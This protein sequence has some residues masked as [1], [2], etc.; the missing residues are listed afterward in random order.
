MIGWI[1]NIADHAARVAERWA[2]GAEVGFPVISM[3]AFS[4]V[5]FTGC[6]IFAAAL[7]PHDTV[8]SVEPPALADPVP[9][10]IPSG[11]RSTASP[12]ILTVALLQQDRSGAAGGSVPPAP[13]TRS[14]DDLTITELVERVRELE[15]ENARLRMTNAELELRLAESQEQYEN[16]ESFITDHDTY[17]T[18]FEEYTL[19]RELREREMRARAAADAKARR[20]A[21]RE[22]RRQ[23][24]LEARERHRREQ[25]ARRGGPTDVAG[26]PEAEA[27]R[28]EEVLRRAGYT[29]VGEA[30]YV[31]EM[32][33]SYRTEKD[34]EVRY[35]YLLKTWYVD[36][37]EI[38]DFSDMTLSGTVIHAADDTH[39]LAV[40]IAF[41][42]EGGGQIGETVV[43][44]EGA[45]S[46][47]PYPFTSK[48]AMAADQPFDSYTA[49]VLYFDPTNQTP[50]ASPSTAP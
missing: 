6:M 5:L 25:S 39:D 17:G 19:F 21:E 49:W 33:T 40:A 30:V 8:G 50:P 24:A 28:R 16:L 42:N 43:R 41:F 4:G 27:A 44:V 29:R 34:R 3:V 32:G 26:D 45:R 35:S 1:L 13:P 10:G 37:D 23:R 20:E 22:A 18:A 15:H 14:L 11:P 2:R 46:G 47:V 48:I 9:Q 7:Q 31:S 36:E 38:V 12:S